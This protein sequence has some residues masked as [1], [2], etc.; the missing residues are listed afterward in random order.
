MKS[1]VLISADFVT[2]GGMDRANHALADYLARQEHAVHLV[3][4][5]ASEDLTAQANVV[6][7]RIPKV[8]GSYFLSEPL[9]R[10]G[11]LSWERRVARAGG[12]VVANGGNCPCSDVNWVHYVHAAH[13]P[14]SRCGRLRHFKT[15]L[16]HHFA[17]AAERLA[18]RRA[19]LIVTN[20]EFTRRHVLEYFDVPEQRVRTV[21]YGVDPCKF[22][23]LHLEKQVEAKER[24]G[25]PVHR[26]LATFIGALGD[27]RKGFDTLF[28][29]WRQLARSSDWDVD[30][31]VIGVGAELALWQQRTQ[32]AG[33]A[34]RIR[35]LGFRN[36]VHALLPLCDVLVA[37]T[38]YE[39]YGLG[40]H[41]ALCCGVP[42][43]VSRSAGVAERYPPTLQDLLLHDPDD[44]AALAAQLRTWRERRDLYRDATL[45][46]SHEL[47]AYTWDDMSQ[48]M[49]Q[50]MEDDS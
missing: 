7:H 13:Q 33:L 30:L 8:L 34:Q 1:Y 29:A 44:A 37:P 10:R 24:L 38:R 41:E 27:R 22:H 42:A 28:D 12:R 25:W 45:A 46:L 19:R 15:Q 49:V 31:I 2:T 47:R 18:F 23:P 39:A 16:A 11:G 26:P 3:T 40:V 6:L 5:R 43:I 9:L 32:E 14:V 36:D 21:Y 17:L 48:R 20:S 50:M 4:Y 35:F